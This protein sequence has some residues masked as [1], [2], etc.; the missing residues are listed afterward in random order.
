MFKKKK[1]EI[2]LK[3]Y[4]FG[5]IAFGLVTVVCFGAFNDMSSYPS[6]SSTSLQGTQ[7]YAKT[8]ETKLLS[9]DTYT[10]LFQKASPNEDVY[11][12]F[13]RSAWNV[14]SMVINSVTYPFQVMFAINA[15]LLG[16]NPALVVPYYII[17]GIVSMIIISLVILFVMAILRLK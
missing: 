11:S 1:A 8:N 13:L 12:T 9:S 14:V 17:N 6:Y 3:T 2:D 4:L 5:I 7:V 16:L 10:T 15:D